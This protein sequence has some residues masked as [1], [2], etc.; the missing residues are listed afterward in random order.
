MIFQLLPLLLDLLQLCLWI[1]G[2]PILTLSQR[3]NS[4]LHLL[5][6]GLACRALGQGADRRHVDLQSRPRVRAFLSLHVRLSEL[7]RLLDHLL[8]LRRREA[9]LVV[10]QGHDVALARPLILG[11]QAQDAVG[12]DFEGDLNLRRPPRRGVDASDLELSEQMVVARQ[13]AFALV[14]LEIEP[15]LVL[16]VSRESGRVFSWKRGPPPNHFRHDAPNGLN[17]KGQGRD[18]VEDD[19]LRLRVRAQHASLNRC[20]IGHRLVRVDASGRL[21]A[22]EELL[23]DLL[24]LWD[25]RGA[26]DQNDLINLVALQTCILQSPLQWLQSPL[27]KLHVEFVEHR[28]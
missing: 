27:E 6:A 11:L 18:V 19:I 13:W 3:L 5:F 23:D 10:R 16:V 24:H 20:A 4:L 26:S 15:M 7:L 8:D 21:F 1:G 12:V 25:P 14:N 9:V 22:V 28:A 2:E 17:A